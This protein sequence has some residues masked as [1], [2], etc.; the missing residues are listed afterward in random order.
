M[1][2]DGRFI[3]PGAGSLY[4]R[5]VQRIPVRQELI[6]Y[7]A[8][9]GGICGAGS[10]LNAHQKKNGIGGGLGGVGIL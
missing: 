2:E 7:P 1:Q 8:Q 9:G 6:A 5:P 4:L 3:H 10:V